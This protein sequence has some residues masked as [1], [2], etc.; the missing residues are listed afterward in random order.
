MLRDPQH[1]RK[2]PNDIRTPPFVLSTVEGL[3]RSFSD[4]TRSQGTASRMHRGSFAARL[5]HQT[6]L[7]YFF[8]EAPVAK[9]LNFGK[10]LKLLFVLESKAC[11]AFILLQN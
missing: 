9:N 2:I 5:L 10:F 6:L 8:S 3:R 1:E 4:T 7:F 11:H